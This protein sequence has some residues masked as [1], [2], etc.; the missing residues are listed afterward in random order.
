MSSFNYLC[1]PAEES[2]PIPVA[3]KAK[4]K[5]TNLLSTYHHEYYSTG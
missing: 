1:V 3:K 4:I 5:E 2:R